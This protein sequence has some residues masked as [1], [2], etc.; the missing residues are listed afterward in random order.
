MENKYVQAVLMLMNKSWLMLKNLN[1]EKLI[2]TKRKILS[3][4]C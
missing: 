1:D 3:K 4:F 2:T